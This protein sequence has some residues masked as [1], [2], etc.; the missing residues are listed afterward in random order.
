M[1]SGVVFGETS[2]LNL[3]YPVF[4]AQQPAENP[5]YYNTYT[6]PSAAGYDYDAGYQVPAQGEPDRW[7]EIN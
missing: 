3:V 7:V 2:L 1:F 5:G 6:Y 4:S